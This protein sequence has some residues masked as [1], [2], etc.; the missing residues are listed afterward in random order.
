ME[1]IKMTRRQLYLPAT[2]SRKLK[3]WS[4]I[5]K[6]SESEIMRRALSDYLEQE[7]RRKT[8]R[9]KNPVLNAA[10]VF[11][12]GPE[13]LDAGEKHDDIVYGLENKGSKK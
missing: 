11:E 1:R 5:N 13:C 6:I 10:G 4:K 8:P 9:D 3:E 7:R 2:L 12:G